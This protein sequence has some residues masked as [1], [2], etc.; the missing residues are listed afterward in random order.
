[1]GAMT[2]FVALAFMRSDDDDR[3]VACEPKEARS[4][5]QAVRMASQMA[6][7]QG[8]CGALA[9]SRTGDPAIGEFED[10]VILRTVG[11]VDAGLLVG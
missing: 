9:F 3:I 1:M 4:A 8:H 11:E 2:Y 7:T 10:A 6:A 5:E